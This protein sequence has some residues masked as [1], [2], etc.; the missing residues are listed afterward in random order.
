MTK[1]FVPCKDFRLDGLDVRIELLVA[2]IE[3]GLQAFED[4]AKF[5]CLESQ[6]R[7]ARDR[8]NAKTCVHRT[9]HFRTVRHVEDNPVSLANTTGH[10]SAG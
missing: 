2:K 8:P 6:V 10:K 3:S 9:R 1:R 5:S 4:L 7:R